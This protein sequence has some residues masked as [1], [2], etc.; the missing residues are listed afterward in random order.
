MRNNQRR[1]G[2]Q[3][4]PQPAAASSANLAY[5]VPTEFVE[6][7]S[8]GVFYPE[9]H[10]LFNQETVEIKFMTA[11]DEDIL[12]SQALIK[13]G[14]MIDRL[15]ESLIVEDVD[16]ISLLLADKT[17]IIIAARISGYGNEYNASVP[18]VSCTN[19]IEFVYDLKEAEIT[20]NCFDERYLH[21]NN[22]IFSEEHKTFDV[23]LPI[24][25]MK[26]SISPITGQEEKKY[27]DDDSESRANT[28][29]GMLATFIV[30]VN[31]KSSYSDVINFVEN[32]PAA[33]SKYLRDLYSSLTPRVELSESI[34]CHACLKT[35]TVEVPLSAEFFWPR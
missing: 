21:E 11:K 10:P 22:V 14:I 24:S 33:D 6:L 35:Q 31:D 15:L 9:G 23:E 30:A 1:T 19:R 28:I 20:G 29:T 32:M 18:C 26:V 34:A 2:P 4:R 5:V 16:P 17:A 27:L 3:A 12:S 13:K 8:K 25:K 7:P